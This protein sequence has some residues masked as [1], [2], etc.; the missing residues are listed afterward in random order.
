MREIILASASPRR[1][2]I[3]NRLG[4]PY[5]VIVSNISEKLNEQLSLE[6]KIKDLAL[7]KAQAVFVEHQDCLVIGADTIVELDGEIIGKPHSM[8]EARAMIRKL[9]GRTHRVVTAV[10]IIS[11]DETW[12]VADTAY[13]T[14][15]EISEEE[16]ER[17]IQT[18][19]PYDKAGGY[20]VQGWASVFIT[21]INGSYY[22]IMG[23]P[24]HLVYRKLREL[25]YSI[26]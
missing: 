2:E 7:Q 3:M 10:A 20:A 18:K 22:T 17:Y 24:L 12:T 16:I 8:T 1:R 25:N 13:V 4:I 5:K 15:D 23:F 6:D 19:E 26:G 11:E 21:H 14:F 9:S